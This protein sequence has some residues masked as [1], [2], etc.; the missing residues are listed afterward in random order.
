V[1]DRYCIEWRQKATDIVFASDPV[2]VRANL[3]RGLRI[4]KATPTQIV[5]QE[6]ETLNGD[7]DRLRNWAR[8]AVEAGEKG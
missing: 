2:P 6:L 1:G 5:F 3:E 8:M 7:P 4:A